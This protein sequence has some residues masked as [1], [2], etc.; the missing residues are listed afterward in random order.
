[1]GSMYAWATPDYLLNRMTFEQVIMYY[2]YGIAFEKQKSNLL[3]NRLAVGLF[4]AEEQKDATRDYNPQPDKAAF[5]EKYGD[6]I[7]RP[8][9]VSE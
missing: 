9:G 5:Y 8:E 3:V 6:K 4:G 7:K 1:M 2:E